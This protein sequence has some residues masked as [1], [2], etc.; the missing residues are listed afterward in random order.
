MIRCGD[1]D[2]EVGDVS[3]LWLRARIHQ[4]FSKMYHRDRFRMHASAR[5]LSLDDLEQSIAKT[6]FPYRENP[7]TGVN[8]T[9]AHGVAPAVARA[10]DK[11]TRSVILQVPFAAW[12]LK[13]VGRDTDVMDM[14]L[15]YLGVLRIRLNRFLRRCPEPLRI[16]NE[17]QTIVLGVNPLARAVMSGCIQNTQS[18]KCLTHDL[19]IGFIIDPLADVFGP[20]PRRLNADEFYLLNTR[21]QSTYDTERDIDPVSSFRTDLMFFRGIRDMSPES[22]ASRIT[23]EDLR[24][25]QAAY[26]LMPSERDEWRRLLGHSW[27][28]RNEDTTECLRK[29]LRYGG[30][31]VELAMCLYKQRNFHGVTAI[32]IG[33]RVADYDA[34]MIPRELRRIVEYEGNFRACRDHLRDMRETGKPALPFIY[35]IY[36]E[37]QLSVESLRRHEASSRYEACLQRVTSNADDLLWFGSY[38]ARSGIVKRIGSM[39]EFCICF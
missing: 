6:D 32:V 14:F 2:F 15:V 25:F 19:N 28:H 38:T 7:L 3:Q 23:N 18:W 9:D 17:L 13:A 26:A 29:D 16:K 10:I 22:L 37:Y 33:L 1:Q 21:F 11:E 34:T 36:R 24:C 31:L 8:T 35:P 4:A 30:P 5:W 20:R 39:F 27:R 12:L